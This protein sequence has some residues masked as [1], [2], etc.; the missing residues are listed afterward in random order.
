VASDGRAADGEV[1]YESC[2]RATAGTAG[3]AHE[4]A[5]PSGVPAKSRYAA[6]RG[7]ARRSVRPRRYRS[8]V[9]CARFGKLT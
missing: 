5:L 8:A 1:E 7:I 6:E 9:I 4:I 2:G 3:A